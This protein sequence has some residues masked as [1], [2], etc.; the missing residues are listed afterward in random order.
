[1]PDTL[2]PP[3]RPV[4]DGGGMRINAPPYRA[5]ERA[6]DEQHQVG[7]REPAK[8]R[9]PMRTIDSIS[10]NFQPHL[11]ETVPERSA[12]HAEHERDGAERAGARC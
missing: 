5:E 12:D 1:M 10:G 7:G 8:A 2:P 11:S 3:R 6:A 4:L 9:G